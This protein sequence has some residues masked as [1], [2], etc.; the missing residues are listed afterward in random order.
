MSVICI[1]VVV[2]R[3]GR[4]ES[5]EGSGV[6]DE[7]QR[8]K[9]RALGNTRGLVRFDRSGR[10]KVWGHVTYAF[11]VTPNNGVKH[12]T[13]K[14]SKRTTHGLYLLNYWQQRLRYR[15]AGGLQQ[16][17]ALHTHISHTLTYDTIAQSPTNR[18]VAKRFRIF[19]RQHWKNSSQYFAYF[20]T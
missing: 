15:H 5:A 16:I 17:R 11:P 14:T 4:D 8:T 3:K 2:E 19:C 10:E 20:T 1:K 6:H 18:I 7:K 13:A 9:Y 12:G